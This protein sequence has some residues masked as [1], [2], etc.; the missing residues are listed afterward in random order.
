MSPPTTKVIPADA[1][2]VI[3]AG[4][5]VGPAET[6]DVGSAKASDVTTTEASHMTPAKAAAHV[7]ATTTAT[8]A[9][10]TAAA[11]GLCAR[12]NKAA[13]KQSCCQNHRQSSLHDL[14]PLGWAVIPPQDLR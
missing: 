7:A 14:S 6:A 2:N 10:A 5:H 8:M 1:C 13:G 3:C 11:A 9:A 4:T 12:G